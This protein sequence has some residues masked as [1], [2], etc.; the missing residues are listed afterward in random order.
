[1]ASSAMGPGFAI[2]VFEFLSEEQ[3]NV[4]VL[5]W[6]FR[7]PLVY[8]GGFEGGRQEQE[9]DR[10]ATTMGRAACASLG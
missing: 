10:Q 7:L 4:L 1:M 2:V 6:S 5:G 8:R 3:R 9:G